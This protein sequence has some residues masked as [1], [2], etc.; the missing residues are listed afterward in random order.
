MPPLQILKALQ[1]QARFGTGDG[2]Q[3]TTSYCDTKVFNAFAE[4]A[5]A[6]DKL[7]GLLEF[8]TFWKIDLCGK[9]LV[10]VVNIEDSVANIFEQ[11]A[12][13]AVQQV[14]VP[15]FSGYLLACC[16]LDWAWMGRALCSDGVLWG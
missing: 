15:P 2:N 10:E 4:E 6:A 14:C 9:S 13:K 1:V 5:S 3:A 11:N 7:I 12:K 16:H 8:K